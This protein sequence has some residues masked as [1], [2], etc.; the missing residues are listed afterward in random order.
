LKNQIP[1]QYWLGG[2]LIFQIGYKCVCFWLSSH[3]ISRIV[4]WEY[5]QISLLG[6]S[7]Y[8]EIF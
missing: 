3:Q 7:M 8:L 1:A 2:Y 6:F 5:S 4:F